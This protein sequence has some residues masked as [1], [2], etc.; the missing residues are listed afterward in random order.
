MILPN[1]KPL[2]GEREPSGALIL[3]QYYN[4]DAGISAAQSAGLSIWRNKKI[5]Q[6]KRW[7]DNASYHISAP[8]ILG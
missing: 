5:G 4:D 6:I 3:L 1:A 7:Q 2:A 8:A